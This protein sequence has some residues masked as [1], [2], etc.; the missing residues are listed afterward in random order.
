MAFLRRIPAHPFFIAAYAVLALLAVN[1]S[2]VALGVALRPLVLSVG[3]T[4]LLLVLLFGALRDWRKAALVTSFGLI[5]FFAYGHL[6]QV[7]EIT[8]ILNFQ[9]GRHRYF[10]P[11]FSAVLLLGTWI[12]IAKIRSYEKITQWLNIL[13]LL[14]LFF[15]VFQILSHQVQ[16]SNRAQAATEFRTETQLLTVEDPQALPDIYY[17]VLDTYTRADAL[18]RDLDFDNTPFLEAL[19]A[20]GFYVA[21]CS[22]SNYSYTQSSLTSAL[23]LDYLPALQERLSEGGFEGEAVWVLLKNSLVREGLE[24]IG[25]QTVGFETGYEWSRLGD[26]DIYLGAGTASYVQQT[27]DPFEAMV[28]KSTA[29]LILLDSW[30]RA[31]TAQNNRLSDRITEINFP[32]QGHVQRQLFILETLPEIAR[33]PG[34]KFVFAHLLIPH[35]PYVFGA[36]GEILTDPGYYG[37]R[38]GGP[39]NDEYERLGYTSQVQF[40]NQ[41]MLAI[42][43]AIIAESETPPVII[44]QGDHGLIGDNRLLILN[45]LYLPDEAK[46]KLYPHI[47]PVNSFRLIFDTFFGTAYGFLPDHSYAKT[48][49]K[50]PVPEEF[51]DCDLE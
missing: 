6:Y 17:L 23:N 3:L 22:R 46:E 30:S 49:Y 15:P 43:Q 8:P 2:E 32:Y 51:P 21:S 12:I 4:G 7:L 10:I 36:D 38:R 40:I 31:W 20:Q 45:A 48:D 34:Q 35:V 33:M 26:A 37:G 11:A 41:R 14:L 13:T 39:I 47:S 25:Y 19:E 1:I 28:A 50:N 16:L 24:A 29:A 44:I 42:T 5:L 9:L 27:I 18:Q